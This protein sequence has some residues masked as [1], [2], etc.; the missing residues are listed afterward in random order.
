[1]PAYLRV[2]GTDRGSLG[3]RR[4]SRG[5]RG[6]VGHRSTGPVDDLIYHSDAGMP[7]RC[8]PPR[9]R[10][11]LQQWLEHLRRVLVVIVVVVAPRV[12]QQQQRLRGAR[13]PLGFQQPTHQRRP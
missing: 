12:H 11:P 5:L 3:H 9:G 6:G 8:P 1:M 10:L 2:G 7:A 4:M 13:A